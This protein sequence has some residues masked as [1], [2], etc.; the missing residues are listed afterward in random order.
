MAGG[1]AGPQSGSVPVGVRMLSF[2][3]AQRPGP[4]CVKRETSMPLLDPN[5][6]PAL[7]GAQLGSWNFGSGLVIS[8]A[9]SG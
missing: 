1:S 8:H 6:I 3:A 4:N 7:S 5:A 2:G 9:N